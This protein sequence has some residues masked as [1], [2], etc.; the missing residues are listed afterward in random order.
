[1]LVLNLAGGT[2]LKTCARCRQSKPLAEFFRGGRARPGPGSYCK[3]CVAERRRERR[4]A[5]PVL[6]A[7]DARKKREYW[8]E[9]TYGLSMVDATAL[10]DAADGR[11][12]ICRIVFDETIDGA[13]QIDHNH[14]TGA[15]RGVLCRRCNTGLGMFVDDPARLQA[16]IAYLGAKR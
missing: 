8:Y 2:A 4:A 13:L 15:V 14:V 5:D 7:S 11:C 1:M 10:V 16:A 6:A 12:Q 3:G 9:R